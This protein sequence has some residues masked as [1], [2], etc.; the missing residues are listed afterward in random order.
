MTSITLKSVLY[1]VQEFDSN[2]L[3]F[4]Y[5][6]FVSTR[7]L[8]LYLSLLAHLNGKFRSFSY[9]KTILRQG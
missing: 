3:V 2:V 1:L 7:S 5:N 6:S 4:E 9:G 8:Y